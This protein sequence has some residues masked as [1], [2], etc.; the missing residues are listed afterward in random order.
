MTGL[1]DKTIVLAGPF[2]LLL[3]NLTTKLAEH[4]AD[5]AL[6]TDDVKSAQRVCQNI[7]DMREVSEKYGR[8]AA[9]EATISDEKSAEN[10]FSRSAEIFG[11]TDVYIDTHLFGLKLPFF[12]ET[13]LGDISSVF[14][15]ALK[16]SQLMTNSAARFLKGRNRGRIL[17]LIQELDIWAAE[18]AQSKVYEEFFDYVHKL[19]VTLTS[20][21]TSV[22]ALAVGANEE[23]LLSRFA[24]SLTI[25]RALQELSKTLPHAKLVDY[26]EIA[27]FTSFIVSPMSSGLNGQVIRLD[28]GL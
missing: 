7:M 8:A 5:V 3:Q 2:G 27:N 15:T 18:K 13:N 23:F 1:N 26:N 16:K 20:Q 14:S 9:I 4:G 19:G 11:S 24:K 17:Y 12:A 28:H 10:N 25:Q 21:H 6:I 22:N